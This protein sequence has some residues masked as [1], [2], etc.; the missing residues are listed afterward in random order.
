MAITVIVHGA[1]PC[2]DPARRSI[3]FDAP[4]V[5]LGRAESC[6]LRL[7]DPSVS[8]R[9]LTIRPTG[10]GFVLG[11][12]GSTNGTFVGRARL[13]ALAPEAIGDRALVRVGRYVL[14]LVVGAQSATA[15]PAASAKQIALGLV[16]ERLLEEGDDTRPCLTVEDGADAGASIV[17]APGERATIG[18]SREATLAL[19][20][21]DTSRRHAEV[22]WR[23][24]AIFARDLGSKGGSSLSGRDLGS[25]DTVWRKSV[26]LRVGGTS[27]TCV[28]EAPE[29]LAEIERAP[30]EKV[31]VGSLDFSA[32]EPE[33][34]PVDDAEA[35]SPE[36]TSAP[37]EPQ[38]FDEPPRRGV[39]WGVTD[40][41]VVMLALGVFSLSA[42]GYFVLL[43]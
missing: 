29:A 26:E 35:T 31:A 12:E 37:D 1:R 19:T 24:D 43:R 32:F 42:V 39:A 10:R 16:I 38:V 14:E 25:S 9:H 41:A 36:D 28:F 34:E 18:R 4:R 33:P 20:D 40:V 7:P 3:T 17:L 23:G 8:L 15:Q 27:I 30:D 21:A 11:D 5:V 13:S 6:D 22:V 2:P